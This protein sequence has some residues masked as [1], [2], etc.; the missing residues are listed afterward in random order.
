VLAYSLGVVLFVLGI[1]LSVALHEA[2]HLLTAKSFG[3][4]VRRYFVGYG[5]TAF[6]IR[7]GETEYGLKWLPFGGFC[8]I[9]GMTVLD[10]LKP[11]EVSR[12]M[13]RY[14]AWKRTVVLASG[15]LAHFLLGFAVLYAM[16]ATMGLPNLA[17]TPEVVSVAGAAPAQAAGIQAGDRIVAVAGARTTTYTD[18]ISRLQRANGPTAVEVLRDGHPLALT[19]NV[20]GGVIGVTFPRMYEYNPVTAIGGAAGFTGQMFTQSWQRL[21]ELPQRIPAVVHSIFGG[22]RDPDSPV[23]VVGMSRIGG[24]AVQQGLWPLFFLLLASFNF[25]IGVFNLLPLL[26][27]DGGHIAVISY[28]RVRDGVRRLCGKAAAGPVD[29]TRLAGVTMVLVFA[30]GAVTLLTVAADLVNPVRLS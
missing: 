22:Q 10:E 3:M 27:M 7:R 13:W 24:E 8:D 2:A 19:V 18:V 1:C 25:F 16:A 11:D 15:S 9:A 5:P 4:R 29:Y 12:A 26:P 20:Q 23:S 14:P 21:I 30:G 28:E 17:G 6:S